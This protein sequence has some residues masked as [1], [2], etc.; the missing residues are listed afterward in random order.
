ME[1]KAERMRRIAALSPEKRQMFEKM[2]HEKRPAKDI[3][4]SQEK[5]PV[6]HIAA[7]FTPKE[8][9]NFLQAH[10]WDES[11]VEVLYPLSP[12]QGRAVKF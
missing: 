9:E 6:D 8:Y 12:M 2:L 4:E 3:P 11:D 10:S 5:E 7:H 1:N